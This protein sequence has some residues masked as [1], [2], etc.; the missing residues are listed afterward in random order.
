[1]QEVRSD[2]KVLRCPRCGLYFDR[3]YER[4]NFYVFAEIEPFCPAC[5]KRAVFIDITPNIQEQ[6]DPS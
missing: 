4:W 6:F 3:R 1:M 2:E 5:R